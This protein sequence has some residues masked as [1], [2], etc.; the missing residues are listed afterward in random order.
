GNAG[1]RAIETLRLEK[2]YRAWGAEIGPD[3]TPVE[4]GL[5]WAC[6]MKS[7]LPFIGRAALEA[8]LAGGV[9][10]LLAGF[11]VAEQVVLLGRETIF[12]DGERVGWLAS[13]GFG[14]SVDRAIGY[15]FV[16]KAGVDAAFLTSG[17]Y[18]LEVAAERIPAQLH[19][20]A[21]Y[22]PEGLRIRG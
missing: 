14:H 12:R 2:G 22:D 18:E 4:A 16:R 21:L 9:K 13:G 10:K 17:S 3:H 5:L 7:G 19:L 6:K 20:G 1:Y 8:Q 11:S 15:G